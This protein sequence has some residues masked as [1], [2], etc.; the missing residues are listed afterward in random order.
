[1]KAQKKRGLVWGGVAAAVLAGLAAAFTPRALPVDLATAERGP[2]LMTV[3]EEGFTRIHD[4]F[5]LSAPVTGRLRRIEVHAGDSVVAQETLLAEL[6]PVDPTLLDP[7][8]ETRAQAAV[9]AAESARKLAASELE[10]AK[11]ELDFARAE[12]RRSLEL[13][14]DGAI[15]QRDFDRAER[16]FKT[17]GAAVTT[18]REALQVRQFELDQARAQLLSPLETRARAG[19][20]ACIPITAPISGQV[21]QL[22]DPSER[23]AAAG[24]PLLQIG[25]PTQ[26]EIVA[27]LLSTDAVQVEAGQRVLIERWGGEERLEGRV[28]RVE[29]FGFTKISALGIE[30]Q[31][32]NV[33]IDFS[34]PR[35]RWQRL[36]HGYQVEARIVLWR[37]EAALK[38]PLT[39]LFRDGERWAIFV[40]KRGR[41][42]LRHVEIGHRNRLDAE[43]VDGL[44]PGERL[45]V[46]PS[47]R[48]LAGTR[49]TA[50]G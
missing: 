9:Q 2:M 13:V 40:E 37:S 25:D 18:A 24:E 41:A 4:V 32:V 29:P 1:M 10:R 19:E 31:R 15:A 12:H 36:G 7:R 39:A 30:E 16:A 3:D 27:D 49:I 5:T 43:I 47:D 8:S 42:R 50:R 28:R 26:L 21:L 23:V 38:V 22:F 17:A 44:S 46:H 45:V 11:A 20:C 6:E 35:E 14:R 48:I 33:I 34:S